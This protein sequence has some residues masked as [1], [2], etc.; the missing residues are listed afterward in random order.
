MPSRPGALVK[1]LVIFFL[2]GLLCILPEGMLRAQEVQAP[3]DEEGKVE[4]ID[5]ELEAKLGLFSEY[6]NFQEARLFQVSDTTFA[7]EISYQPQDKLFRVRLPLSSEETVNFRRK[8]T[9]RISER[10]P[11]AILNQEGR[12]KLLIGSLALSLGYYGWAVPV[13]L[14]V[15]D[16]KTAVALYMLT[17][18]AGFF[19]PLSATST[20]NVTDAVATLSLYGATRGIVHGIMLNSFLSGESATARGAIGF[21]L[22]MSL[23]EAVLGF[24]VADKS[25]MSTGTAEAIGIVGGDFGLGL[26]IGFAGLMDFFEGDQPRPI[27]ASLLLGSGMGMF[28]GALLA[29]AQPYTRGDAYVVRATGFLGAY[30]PIAILDI[31]GVEEGKVYLATSMLGA[32]GGIGLGHI[33]TKDKD[34]TTGQG[35]L[36]T[37]GELAGGLVGLGFAYLISPSKSPASEVFTMSTSLGA[38]AGFWITYRSFATD[39]HKPE[40][41]SSWGIHIS[42]SM[43]MTSI[44]RIPSRYIRTGLRQRFGP[45]VT[46]EYKF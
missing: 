38:I 2:F 28:G 12:T 5:A 44:P 15:D 40:G 45:S 32:V 21:G 19:L 9:E 17:S 16:G 41:H 29:N 26:G 6:E 42:P 3:V 4:Y 8:V 13:T 34:F 23:S 46:V 31:A 43:P 22:L 20:I 10:A 35:T 36:I 37:L 25:A 18:G 24:S 27:A 39:A 33:L 1:R 11:Q 14:E 7:L 30:T